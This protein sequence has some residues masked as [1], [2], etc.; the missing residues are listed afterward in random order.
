[1]PLLSILLGRSSPVRR[2]LDPGVAP[3]WLTYFRGMALSQASKPVGP[4]RA[5]LPGVSD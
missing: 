1:M 4:I 3:A 5:L 2:L